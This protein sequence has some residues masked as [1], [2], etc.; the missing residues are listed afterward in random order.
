MLLLCLPAERPRP[1]RTTVRLVEAGEGGRGAACWASC[2]ASP[3]ILFSSPLIFLLWLLL[4]LRSSFPVWLYGELPLHKAQVSGPEGRRTWNRTG[5][6]RESKGCMQGAGALAELHLWST[7]QS[8]CLPAWPSPAEKLQ[9]VHVTVGDTAAGLCPSGCHQQCQVPHPGLSAQ[10][11]PCKASLRRNWVYSQPASSHQS[12]RPHWCWW[13]KKKSAG[14][15]E[16]TSK[17]PCL[18][19]W[20]WSCRRH[21][22]RSLPSLSSQHQES[23]RVRL[24]HTGT[25][26]L[27]QKTW[28]CMSPLPH[29]ELTV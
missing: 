15:E 18:W 22:E 14:M 1:G 9:S 2:F 10:A 26:W 25:G 3:T 27:L 4:S 20:P 7:R 13:P 24:V 12:R 11:F 19:L 28:V 23:H 16:G 17:T 5:P 29:L 8:P 6:Q 21:L